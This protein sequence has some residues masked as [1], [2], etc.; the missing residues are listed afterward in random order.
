MHLGHLEIRD[1]D[2][3]RISAVL[4]QS[5]FPVFSEEHLV[6]RSFEDGAHDDSIWFVVIDDEYACHDDG[7]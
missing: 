2:V 3:D 1:D 4:A 7:L 6:T 5:L